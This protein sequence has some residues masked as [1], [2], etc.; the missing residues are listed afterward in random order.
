MYDFDF[1]GCGTSEDSMQNGAQHQS[2]LT[3]LGD[4]RSLYSQR[5]SGDFGTGHSQY[6]TWD[7]LSQTS[8]PFSFTFPPLNINWDDPTLYAQL[9]PLN[10]FL[11]ATDNP[12]Q[13]HT[14]NDISQLENLQVAGHMT[15]DSQPANGPAQHH[16]I[17][18]PPE[19][20]AQWHTEHVQGNT[21]TQDALVGAATGLAS[22][23]NNSSW[24]ARN[25]NRPI[26]EPRVPL[27]PAQKAR[28]RKESEEAL[29]SSIRQLLAEQAQRMN[30]IALEHGVSVEKVKKLMGG[31][32]HY[33]ASRSA[34]LENALMH[35][36]AEEVNKDL[37]WGAKY[38]PGE[39]RQMVKDNRNMQNLTEEEKKELVDKLSE[40]RALRNM[41]V[42]ATNMVA[43]RDVQSTL[44]TIFKMLDGLAV[45]TG[46]YACLFTSRG[47]VYDTT[48]AT[49]FG[50]NNIMDFWE[51]VLQVEAN[52][53]IWKLEQWA[54]M[55]GRNIDECETVQN[56]QR[57]CTRLLNS[58]L[59]TLAKRR[60]IRIN[61]TNFD[62]AIKEKLSIDIKG[63][64]EGVVFQS[65]T[66]VNDL[67]A[68]LKLRGALKDGSCHWFRMTPHQRD[69]FHAL[70]DAC[71]KRGEKGKENA[72]PRK[73]ARAP[74]SSAQAPKSAEFIDSSEEEESSEDKV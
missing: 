52:E 49:W 23:A 56:M 19:S 7:G 60:D 36:K 1:S 58:G 28:Q 22:D 21:N 50:T 40:H 2:E 17:S 38:T 74:G 59:R 26:I 57:V 33:T 3:M 48:Q 6:Q 46:I 5:Q 61:Y 73:R 15:Q 12:G 62:T 39:I 72:P 24:A 54:C 63:W 32:K 29:H 27:N 45:R 11:E 10:N 18:Q 67:P 9:P 13:C 68:L 42:R 25:P 31:T 71:H 8:A 30:E 47:H 20:L 64:P 14:E 16:A 66:S 35:A 55:I 34:Q 41:S 44:D 70:L 37:P 69:E 53:I 65:P 51:D 43:M 4:F